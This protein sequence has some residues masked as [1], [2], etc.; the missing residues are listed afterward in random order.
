MLLKRA[1]EA[2]SLGSTPSTLAAACAG[3]VLAPRLLSF[4]SMVLDTVM[5]AVP[6][7][8]AN[9]PLPTA[10]A[11]SPSFTTHLLQWL[12]GIL[13]LL[14]SHRPA[15]PKSGARQLEGLPGV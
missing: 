4:I 8:P 11:T 14:R 3:A 10:A 2:S 15:A 9:N 6:A 7:A 12:P 13:Q 1:S 5:A